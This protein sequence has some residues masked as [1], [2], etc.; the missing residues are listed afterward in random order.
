MD[1]TSSVSARRVL[2]LLPLPVVSVPSPPVPL[3]LRPL[4]VGVQVVL[5]VRPLAIVALQVEPGVV[6]AGGVADVILRE[7]V[8]VLPPLSRLLGA[9][10]GDGEVFLPVVGP[11]QLARGRLARP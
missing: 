8:L 3:P 1:I 5:S 2:P 6:P 10:L 11:V 4:Q 9:Q 7:P